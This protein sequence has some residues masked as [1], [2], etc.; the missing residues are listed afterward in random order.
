MT[1]TQSF[2]ALPQF[3]PYVA[4]A[5]AAWLLA[6][7]SAGYIGFFLKKPVLKA[8]PVIQSAKPISLSE[9]PSGKEEILARNLFDRTLTDPSEA[10]GSAF[11]DVGQEAVLTDL[12]LTLLGTFVAPS[13]EDCIAHIR[14]AGKDEGKRVKVGQKI[15][16]KHDVKKILRGRVEF[17]NADNRRLEFLGFSITKKTTFVASAKPAPGANPTAF[18]GINRLSDTEVLISQDEWNAAMKNLN[19]ILTQASGF[20]TAEGF[21]IRS[22]VPGSIYQKLG[23]TGGDLL[24]SVNNEKLTDISKALTTFDKLRSER[25]FEITIRRGGSNRT[26]KYQIV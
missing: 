11:V 6:H 18:P 14:E 24:L 10:Q 26:F 2:K 19:N 23:I 7:V 1:V 8:A 20:Q 3:G 25:N 22:I 15:M 12:K 13:D 5:A 16:D 9:V 21:Q 17:V 4:V